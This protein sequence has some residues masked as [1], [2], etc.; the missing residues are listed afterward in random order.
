M[1]DA[2]ALFRELEQIHIRRRERA[3]ER[4]HVAISHHAKADR[5]G[6]MAARL[7]QLIGAKPCDGCGRLMHARL[8]QYCAHC[9]STNPES[10]D[11]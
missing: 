6:S 9:A 10:A 3:I 7:E 11:G 2:A 4:G 1:T 8:G 5:L